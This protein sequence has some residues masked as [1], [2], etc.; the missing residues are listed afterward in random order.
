MADEWKYAK[1]IECNRELQKV[2]MHG[3]E[4]VFICNDC[5]DSHDGPGKFQGYH[6][7]DLVTA[8][9]LYYHSLD[10]PDES[11][12]QDGWGYCARIGQYLIIEDDRGFVEFS[13]EG[14][15]EKARKKYDQLYADGW[16]MDEEDAYIEHS[17]HG[18]YVRFGGQNLEI[19]ARGPYDHDDY[20]GIDQNRCIARVRLEAMKTGFYPNLWLV[21]ERGNIS[22]LQY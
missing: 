12:S 13:D 2:S 10:S 14:S 22:L 1:C 5:V 9:L 17:M 18:W 20:R 11:M 16:G 19:W 8:L 4:G 21:G 15:E 7:E 6:D 3:M